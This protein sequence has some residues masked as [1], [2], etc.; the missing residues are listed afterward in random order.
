AG[1]FS[2]PTR[3]TSLPP[4][5]CTSWPLGE[6]AVLPSPLASPRSATCSSCL[7]SPTR[8]CNFSSAQNSSA[9]ATRCTVSTPSTLEPTFPPTAAGGHLECPGNAPRNPLPNVNEKRC[10]R[11]SWRIHL[12]KVTTSGNEFCA[13]RERTLY[14]EA[15]IQY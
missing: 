11:N 12:E 4:P 10:V 9:A 8:S 14:R 1:Q 6:C 15:V 2:P 7:A 5:C 13:I 3:S